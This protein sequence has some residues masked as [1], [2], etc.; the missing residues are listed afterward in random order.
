MKTALTTEVFQQ[1]LPKQIRGRINQEII[2]GIN[3]TFSDPAMC[4]LYRDNL[5]SYSSV[6]REGKFKI[7]KY[8]EA[9]RYVGFKL[10][11]DANITA[12]TKAFPDRYARLLRG[13][14]SVKD[15]SSFVAAYNK[16]KLV[17]LVYEQ[18]LTPVHILNADVYQ[19]AINMQADIMNDVS[20]S[21][22]VRSDAADSLLRHLKAPEAAKVELDIVVKEDSAIRDLQATMR[23]LVGAQRETIINGDMSSEEVAHSKLVIEHDDTLEV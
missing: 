2:D 3:N 14:S 22:K 9:V 17:N 4:E 18:A 10:M 23:K 16:N 8:I 1:A 6:M 7:D 5:L 21:P 20:V 13:G 11:G 19:S 12:Y 15:I